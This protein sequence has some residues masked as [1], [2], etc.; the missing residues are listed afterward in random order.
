MSKNNRKES[1]ITIIIICL[2]SIAICYVGIIS[3]EIKPGKIVK[4][5]VIDSLVDET[6]ISKYDVVSNKKFVTDPLLTNHGSTILTIIK[7]K[8]KAQIYYASTLDS[9]L[10]SSIDNIANA[11]Y[12]CADNNVDIINMS[13]AT[14]QDNPTLKKAIDYALQKNIIIVASCINNYDG[15]AYPASYKGVVS[16]SNEE[17]SKAKVVISKQEIPVKLLDG[18]TIKTAGASC[19]TAY[20]TNQI[21]NELSG[22]AKPYI[23]NKIKN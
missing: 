19:A 5:G 7:Q 12:W 10:V 15:Y 18:S 22:K 21:S 6:Y 13:F 14:K 4:V 2:L 16:V 9:N 1:V 11:I 3:K 17:S 23:I 20:V 8:S